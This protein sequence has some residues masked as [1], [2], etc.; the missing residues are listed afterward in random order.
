MNKYKPKKFSN[1]NNYAAKKLKVDNDDDYDDTPNFSTFEQELAMFEEM[2]MESQNSEEISINSKSLKDNINLKWARPPALSMDESIDKLIFQQIDIDSYIGTPTDPLSI[3]KETSIVRMYGS[4]KDGNSVTCHVHG[5]FPYFYIDKPSD[6]KDADIPL[7]KQ[8]LHESLR[9]EFKSKTQLTTC[10]MDLEN[11]ERQNLYGY[12]GNKLSNFLKISLALPRL[13]P[14]AK[15]ILERNFVTPYTDKSIFQ[16]YESNIDFEI[17]FMVDSKMVGGS[18]IELPP[19]KFSL[20]KGEKNKITRCQIEVDI[21]YWGDIISHS[22]NE[23]QWSHIA[24]FRILSFDIECSNRK[25]VFPDPAFDS[26][27]QIGNMVAKHSESAPFIRN[28][29]TLN[30]CAP[31][32]GSDV[33]CFDKEIQL[34]QKWA[35]FIRQVDPDI[36]TGYNIQNFDF[37]YLI[38]RANAIKASDFFY[39]GRISY[40]KTGFREST[41]QSKQ[42]GR[43]E[44]KLIAMEGRI[45][46]DLFQNGND[47]T[48]RRLAVYCMKD[49][50]LPLRLLNKLLCLINHIE[51]ARVT[52]VPLN[53]LLTRG[54]QIKVLS[55]LLRKA[56]EK[57]LIIPAYQGESGEEFIGAT[58]IEPI[59]GYYDSPITTLDFSSLYPSIMIAYNLCYSTL[60][61]HD[62]YG[63]SND[64]ITTTPSNNHFVKQ[65]VYTGILPEI[66]TDLMTARKKVKLALK[67]ETD[68]F[69]KQV[70]DG[71]QLAIKISANSVYGFTG[72]QNGKLPC[73]E[74]S[75]SVTAYGRLMIEQT[76]KVIEDHYTI[77]NGFAHDAKVVYGDTDSVMIKFGL[78]SLAETM[79]LG[80]EAAEYV[81]KHFPSPILLEFEKVYFP[82]LL[83]N[84]KRY[85]GLSYTKPEAYDKLDCKGLE[86]VRRDNCPLVSNL[87]NSCLHTILIGRNPQSAVNHAIQIISELLCNKID[88]SQLVV[89]K[90]L[91]KTDKEYAG[92]QAH[93][94]LAHK[95]RKRDPGS[96]P[97]LG[98]R[99]PYVIIAGSKGS[100]AY[101]RAEDPIYVLENN[102]PI[103][104]QYYLDNQISKPLL[105]IFEPILGDKAESIL[106][107]GKHTLTKSVPISKTGSLS[108]FTT[109]HA[110]CLNCKTILY[111]AKT[112]SKIICNHCL[113]VVSEVYQREILKLNELEQNFSELW[114]EC[115]R[116][117]G[118][119]HEDVLCTNQDCPIYYMRK[120]VQMDIG[121]QNELVLKFD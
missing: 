23:P 85:A 10:I 48:R 87:I 91:T 74:I 11:V 102:I 71:R 117:S 13:V 77:S 16:T 111:S 92:K 25:G 113:P 112:D 19:T 54:Q 63:I 61:L 88:I 69:I 118:S 80:R 49:A 94:E 109:K 60:V 53:Y 32:V 79:N 90:E 64:E 12:H 72:A 18:W 17:R 4:T 93:V 37:P 35:E 70:L 52:G 82:Y 62:K 96:A 95:M 28:V 36:I 115:Q 75:Q 119:L 97:S 100:P 68:I 107:R 39:L 114:T 67:S 103:D 33:Y 108:Q 57:N 98:D 101:T 5:F 116:C 120:K 9:T 26:V 14:V 106:L 2:E 7:F 51:M 99:I 89:T 78:T 83:I 76:K 58:V 45:I 6:L 44:N 3:N 31:I 22:P 24:P 56:K 55:Q 84:K 121:N 81:S 50:Y 40:L 47:Q 8:A 86:T 46:F 38:N 105:R 65:S 41:I 29:F 110:Q 42:M 104:T 20:R 30:T 21:P 1:A 15:R 73:L 43:R 34:L 59:K 27:I 66:L